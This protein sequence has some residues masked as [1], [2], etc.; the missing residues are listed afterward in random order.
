MLCRVC[1]SV[2]CTRQNFPAWPADVTRLLFIHLGYSPYSA[3]KVAF[4]A[5]LTENFGPV[6]E[7]TDII[8]DRVITNVGGG[9]EQKTGR[10]TAPFDGVYQFN[11]IVSAQGRRKV[12]QR[13]A[14]YDNLSDS[15]RSSSFVCFFSLTSVGIDLKELGVRCRNV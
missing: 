8:F 1:R 4:F 10:F 13:H 7:H 2:F 12:Q 14:L 3:K 15:S 5:G 6:T 9:F 11:V